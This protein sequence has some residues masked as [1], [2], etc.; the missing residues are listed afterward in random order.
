[1]MRASHRLWGPR[2]PQGRLAAGQRIELLLSAVSVALGAL[3]VLQ[4]LR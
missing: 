3:L 4:A 1:M 2:G